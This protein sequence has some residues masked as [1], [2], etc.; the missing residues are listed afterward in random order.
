MDKILF[1]NACTHKE[2]R[3]LVLASYLLSKLK[4]EITELKLSNLNLKPLDEEGLREREELLSKGDFKAF[5]EANLFREATYIVI[6]SPYYDLSFSALLKLFI[7]NINIDGL[8]FRFT[9]KGEYDKLCQA[10]T[11]YYI[12]TAGGELLEDY[13]FN[14]I[15]HLCHL[16][17][18]IQDV[19]LIKAENLDIDGV[20]VNQQLKNAKQEIDKIL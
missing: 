18:G 6:A 20:D 17:Y 4:G 11:V 16:F 12:T 14:Y 7:E 13:G 19:R 9:E 2:S 3:T 1:V 8:T 15:K 5:R 10:K